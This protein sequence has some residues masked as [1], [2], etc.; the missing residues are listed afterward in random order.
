MFYNY[1]IIE[2]LNAKI[3]VFEYSFL[4]FVYV[5]KIIKYLI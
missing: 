4:I 3:I 5:Y 1:K 2:K